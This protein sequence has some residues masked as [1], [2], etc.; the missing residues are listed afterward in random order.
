MLLNLSNHPSS[1]WSKA[2]LDLAI[3]CYKEVVD[4]PFPHIDPDATTDEVTMLAEDYFGKIKTY[5]AHTVHLMGEHTFCYILANMLRDHGIPCIASTTKRI[6]EELD[7]Q[8][9]AT[10]EFVQF[11]IYY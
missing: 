3:E 10:F 8:K 7:S 11:R 9:I 1:N 4:L 6:V 2:Q 5:D